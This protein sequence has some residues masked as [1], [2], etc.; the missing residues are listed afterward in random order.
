MSRTALIAAAFGLAACGG[1]SGP[2]N[3]F[4]ATLNAANEP[5]SITSSGTGSADYTVDGGVVAFTVTFSGLTANANNAHIHVGP[6]GVAGGVTVPF[7]SQI[8]R[9]TSGTFNG[10]FTAANVA[11]ATAADA[12]ISLNAGDFDGLLTLMRAG[13]TYTNIHTTANVNGEI[14]GQN[15]PR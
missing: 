13:N 12:G 10:T 8:P 5:G 9:A 3:H 6:A 2:S 1:S 14:R 11:A 15:Q 7:T 4:V